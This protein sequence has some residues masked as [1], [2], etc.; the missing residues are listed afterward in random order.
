M[1]DWSGS[2]PRSTGPLPQLNIPVQVH[3]P[4][5]DRTIEIG[6]RQIPCRPACALGPPAPCTFER[7][8]SGLWKTPLFFF[9]APLLPASPKPGYLKHRIMNG[10]ASATP[11]SRT[12]TS[13]SPTPSSSGESR[14]GDREASIY[15]EM[16]RV[17]KLPA[18]SSYAIHRMKVLNKLRHLISVK[19]TTSQDEELELLF[20]SLSI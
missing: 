2:L 10:G 5:L 3:G 18:N 14:Q 6:A 17:N 12:T 9:R 13:L 11:F 7:Q 15:V 8:R 4:I 1:I 20:A 19:R 16:D